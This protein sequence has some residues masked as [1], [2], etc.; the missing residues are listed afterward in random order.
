MTKK[1][2]A[3]RKAAWLQALKEPRVVRI[4]SMSRMTAY[5]TID[6]RDKALA[7]FAKSGI[8]AEIVAVKGD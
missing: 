8:F 3:K 2:A 4:P 5:P 6:A 1:E 7:D